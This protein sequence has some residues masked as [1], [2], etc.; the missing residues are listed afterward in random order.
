MERGVMMQN[1]LTS[2]VSDMWKY[3]PCILRICPSKTVGYCDVKFWTVRGAKED[4][5]LTL[6]TAG[7]GMGFV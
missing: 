4:D 2:S 5:R 7:E 1:G 6:C 3:S